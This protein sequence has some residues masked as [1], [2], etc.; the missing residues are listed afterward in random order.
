MVS[1]YPLDVLACPACRG[2]LVQQPEAL[3]CT[4]CAARYAIEHQVPDLVPADLH[5]EIDGAGR[6]RAWERWRE[7]MRGL[8]TWRTL[9][10]LRA[11]GDRLPPDG[12]SEEETRELF[13]RAGVQGVVVDVGAKDAAK[14]HL[15][16]SGVRYIGIDPFVQRTEE[17]PADATLV[18]GVVE[19]LPIRDRA[20]DAVVCLAAFDYFIDGAAALAEMARVLRPRG[21]LAM[22]VSVVPLVV[23]HARGAHSR[24]SRALGALRA[25]REVGLLP[26]A[27]L[28]VSALALR[29]RPHV[30]YYTRGQCL[31]LI[32]VRFEIESVREVAQSTSTIL[33]IAA[34]K[35]VNRVLSVVR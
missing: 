6:D 9:R 29:D 26:G 30:H 11:R 32:S 21:V 35:K 12:A 14:R 23:A 3:V 27:G 8:E 20:A 15:L 28:L 19:A 5:R 25:M 1:S 34:R 4:Q 22:V 16:P 10:R 31:S 7:A 13:R 2:S 24:S 33:Y 18:R 17:I